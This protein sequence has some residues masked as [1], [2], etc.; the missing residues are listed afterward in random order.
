MFA[1]VCW[2]PFQIINVLNYKEQYAKDEEM[3]LYICDKFQN[4]REIFDN[5]RKVGGISRVYFVGN[6][7]YDSLNG[8]K[9]KEKILKDLFFPRKVINDSV[10]GEF[11]I[12]KKK[13]DYVVSSGYLNFNVLF[14]TYLQ[15][16][17]ENVRC[18]FVDD[19][20]ES[21][22]EKNTWDMYSPIYKKVSHMTHIG[23]AIM[24]V[25]K[26]FVYAPELVAVKTKY[27]EICPLTFGS[28]TSYQERVN[29]VFGYQKND[30]LK[31]KKV[32]YFDQL[33]TCD[34]KDRNLIEI[35][36]KVMEIIERYWSKNQWLIKMHPRAKVDLY[37]EETTKLITSAPWE[38]YCGDIIEDSTILI[39]ISSTA[40]ITPKLIYGKEP[41]VLY[42]EKL[43][44]NDQERKVSQFFQKIKDMYKNVDRFF[45]PESFEE[46]ESIL[47]NLEVNN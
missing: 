1:S 32:I 35:Q 8:W 7:D 14:T 38:L 43:F 41:V 5:L 9:K 37:G 20:M 15:K 13:Y 19:G 42:L 11:D 16:K 33:S 26:L 36:K 10:E 46:L 29:A 40:C 47:T 2:T 45:I 18:Y 25:E 44:I 30:I 27:K 34:F 39:A 31:E 24:N 12:N 21:Y 28:D 17:D 6:I 3:E 23:G 22:L 4:A